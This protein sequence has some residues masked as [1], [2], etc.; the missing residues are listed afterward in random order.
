MSDLL[1]K[2]RLASRRDDVVKFTSSIKD[3]IRIATA[4]LEI[5]KAHTVML[6]EQDIISREDG[7]KLLKALHSVVLKSRYDER[8]E[9]IHMY[10]E[11]EVFKI[12]GTE[13]GGNLHVAKSRN[14]QV[15]TAIRMKLRQELIEI[16]KT[17]V[18]LQKALIDL[19]KDNTE[20]IVIGHTHI[21]PAQPVT[22]G[23][24]L[25]SYIDS[26]QRDFDRIK[27]A[28]LRINRS[29]MGAC[30]LA[31][32][33]FPISREKVTELLGFEGILENSIDAI[34]TRDFLI[35]AM[36]CHTV[37]AIDVGRIVEDLLLWSSYHFDMLELPNDFA[38]TS[39]IMPQK[40]NPDILE[41]IRARM[42][43]VIGYFTTCI[44]T[45]IGLPSSYNL[46]FQEV[47]PLLWA[48][49]DQ[50]LECLSMLSKLI[51]NV[52]IKREVTL[53]KALESLST[54]TELAN[55]IVRKYGVPFRTAHNIVGGIAKHL[56]DKGFDHSMVTPKLISSISKEICDLDLKMD[57]KDVKSALD[58]KEFVKAHNVIGGPSP[59]EV[60]RAIMMR[61]KWID[62]SKNWIEKSELELKNANDKLGRAIDLLTL[63]D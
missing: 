36:W 16:E 29:P 33:S 43:L 18:C 55:V 49:M 24:Q 48:S 40:K 12:I 26:F 41:V 21:Q 25:I 60:K 7:V 47:T 5:N 37:L 42:K 61:T 39:S 52:H 51:P 45:I 10:I 57:E 4:V 56:V 35:E 11:E 15:A 44:N 62:V 3:D 59:T 58:P 22:F 17:I 38:S 8:I 2:G 46:D 14:D 30:A 28:Y 13:K 32:T 23:H 6:M 63:K 54:S 31:T 19:A 1:R 50:I 53:K 9:D 20:T 27:E 34:G